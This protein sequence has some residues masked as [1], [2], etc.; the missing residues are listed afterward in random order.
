MKFSSRDH[1]FIL[2]LALGNFSTNYMFMYLAQEHLTSAMTSIAFSTMLLMN[3]VN[4][5]IFFGVKIESK[6]YLGGLLGIVGI[7]ALFWDDLMGT[8]ITDKSLYGL[9][10]VMTGTL[11]ASFGNMF[12]VRNSR[13][14]LNIFAVNAWGMLYG[15]LALIGF[16]LV[17]ESA[18]NLSYEYKYLGSLIYLAIFGT[19]IAFASYF[20][21][22][23]TM[24]PEKASYAVVLFPIVAV[25]L[26]SAFEGF[27]WTPTIVLGFVL[28]LLGNVIVLTP[29]KKMRRIIRE[30]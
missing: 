28:V 7:V 20:E 1:C 6:T 19:V 9:V 17:Q 4:T 21:L 27:V 23:K 16:C 29:A 18:F 3:I 14:G 24:G 10:L 5:R 22:L 26:S 15:T 12:S 30:P 2:L 8:N 25:C 11:I 13:K